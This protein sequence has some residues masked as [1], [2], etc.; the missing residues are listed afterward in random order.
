MK[1]RAA[2]LDAAPAMG[3]VMVEAWLPAHRGQVPD[4]AWHKR[5][6]EWAPEI[7]AQAWARTL[8]IELR[9]ITH[10]TSCW[11]LTTMRTM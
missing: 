3:R 1:V 8:P 10:A 9:A 4:G 5:V 2:V 11:S 7:S 6:S